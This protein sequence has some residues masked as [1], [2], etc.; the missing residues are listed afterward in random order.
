MTKSIGLPELHVIEPISEADLPAVIETLRNTFGNMG[1]VSRLGR[2]LSWQTVPYSGGQ[3]RQVFIT[4]HAE[5]GATRIR[6]EE[7]LRPM[8]GAYF[9][10][11]MGG[12][13]GGGMGAAIGIGMGVFHSA[14]AAAGLVFTLIG[15]SYTLAR[16][17]FRH[18]GQRR[19]AELEVLADRL[20][21][22]IE[23]DRR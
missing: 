7:N 18:H 14:A 20:V 16:T 19:S 9:G 12:M 8:A 5:T 13:G 3:A 17:L 11:I 2:E 6:I 10:G 22:Y 23:G 15:G 1:Q 21:G 4:V